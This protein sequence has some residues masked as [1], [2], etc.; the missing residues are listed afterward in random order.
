MNLVMTKNNV[1]D[2]KEKIN[3]LKSIIDGLADLKN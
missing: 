3:E 2:N 1:K